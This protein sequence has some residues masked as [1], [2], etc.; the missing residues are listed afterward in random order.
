LTELNNG[1]VFDWQTPEPATITDTGL[2]IGAMGWVHKN[3][4]NSSDYLPMPTKEI[5]VMPY[6]SNSHARV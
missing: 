2:Y 5:P 3:N 4:T 1:Y 6:Y